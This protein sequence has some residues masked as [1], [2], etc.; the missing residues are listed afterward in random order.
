MRQPQ[1]YEEHGPN[2]EKWVCRLK[3]GLYGLKQSGASSART[4][5]GAATDP[6]GRAGRSS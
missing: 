4:R 6:M 5:V 2:G 1:G 3:K